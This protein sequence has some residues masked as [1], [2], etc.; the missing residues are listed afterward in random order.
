MC[1]FYDMHV[2]LQLEAM[3]KTI[4]AQDKSTDTKDTSRARSAAAASVPSLRTI[5][6]LDLRGLRLMH[7]D[8]VEQCR[9][10]TILDLSF[11]RLTAPPPR[12]DKLIGLTTLKLF[13]NRLASTVGMPRLSRLQE[14]EV[15]NNY[16]ENL[17][18][19]I[20]SMCSQITGTQA[21]AIESRHSCTCL[22]SC[23]MMLRVPNTF[24]AVHLGKSKS[25]RAS[26]VQ[27]VA[28]CVWCS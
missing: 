25:V 9:A 13:N 19:R 27:C 16:I 3:K 2:L 21:H 4:A 5:Q 10:L 24:V 26:R 15:H 18:V 6:E 8:G 11:N 12:L 1:L 7:I 14:L 22:F 20:P 23:V 17:K 28:V